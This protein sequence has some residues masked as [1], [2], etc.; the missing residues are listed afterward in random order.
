MI[1]DDR[2][3][4]QRLL[5]E[6]RLH[7]HHRQRVVRAEPLRGDLVD[8]DLQRFHH[9]EVLR[10]RHA[11]ERQER[12]RGPGAAEQGSEREA[13]GH[14]VRIRVVLEQDAHAVLAREEL[15]HL[16]DADA[17]EGAVHL[18]AQDLAHRAPEHHGAHVRVVGQG[19]RPGA[20][21]DDQDG[22][23]RRHLEDRLQDPPEARAAP[24]PL[25]G[26]E[27]HEV[28]RGQ[29]RAPVEA[30]VV[31]R[32]G[33][34]VGVLAGQARTRLAVADQ[35]NPGVRVTRG[36]LEEAEQEVGGAHDDTPHGRTSVYT[37]RP[38]RPIRRRTWSG[39]GRGPG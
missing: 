36:S 32:A 14:R 8:L 11:A 9:R 39:A 31:E 1:D 25:R 16:L 5:A 23:L 24:G 35:E 2:D 19:G 26:H 28:R 22:H 10:P 21:V 7:V 30:R 37:P 18:G 33:Q 15:A 29:V 17:Q 34:R 27:H 3:L 38:D 13:R 20:L 12:G 6:G 4:R